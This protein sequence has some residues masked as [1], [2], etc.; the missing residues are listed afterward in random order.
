MLIAIMDDLL[1]TI[2]IADKQI[3]KFAVAAQLLINQTEEE[4]K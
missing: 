4:H 3:V 1:Y 2:A